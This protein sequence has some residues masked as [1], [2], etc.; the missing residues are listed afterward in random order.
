ML[1][2][3]SKAT[4]PFVAFIYN[5]S[6]WLVSTSLILFTEKKI[7]IFFLIHTNKTKDSRGL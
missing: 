3:K 5:G 2:S 1:G 4:N 7:T 6:F